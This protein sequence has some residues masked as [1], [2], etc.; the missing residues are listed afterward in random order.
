MNH[1]ATPDK[2]TT[3]RTVR[4][5]AI[6]IAL[7]SSILI[8]AVKL[9][10]ANVSNS[11]AIRSDALEGTV[12][13]LA[14]AFGLFSILFAEKPADEDHPYGHGK[15]EHFAAVFEGGLIAL[16]GFLILLDTGSRF[17][18]H[19]QTQDLGKGLLLSVV[20]GAMNGVIGIGLYFAGK[21][22]QSTTLKADGLH[23][24]S[25]FWSTLGLSAG[26]VLALYTGW[27]WIDPIL[28]VMVGIMLFIAGYRVFKPSWNTLLDAVNPES[29]QKVVDRLNEIDIAPVITVHELKTQTFGRDAH[30][31]LHLVIPE[32]YTVKQGHEIADRVV[33]DLQ[34]TL[35]VDSMIHAHLDPCERAYCAEC[36]YA[37]C[38]V[39]QS[40]F[41]ERRKISSQSAVKK[42]TI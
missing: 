24:L 40:P 15:I 7:V 28:A 19:S 41:V 30:I 5:T 14:A 32:F 26:L 31:D 23:L 37:N 34:E 10:A 8:F 3:S 39:R 11:S 12:N 29:I 13:I 35:G 33:K 38:P 2:G 17:L 4:L 25:D 36:P 9:Y 22:H 21:R 16:A 6:V 27:M 18:H 42:G 1:H 20:A